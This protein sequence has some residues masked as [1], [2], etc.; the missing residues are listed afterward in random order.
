MVD[1]TESKTKPPPSFTSSGMVKRLAAVSLLFLL[2]A[3]IFEPIIPPPPKI[4]GTTNGPAVTSARTKLKDGRHVAY[5]EYGVPRDK[6]KNKIIFV[7]GFGCCRYD[8]LKVSQEVLEELSICLI[9]FDRPGYGESDPFPKKTVKSIATDIEELADNL[10]LGSK[11][12]VIGY[13]MGG[14]A[15]WSVLK[16]IPHRLAGAAILGPVINY[17]WSGFP[18]NVTN[19]AWNVQLLADKLA[20]SVAH[21]FP[22]LTHWWNTQKYF[23]SSS[24]ITKDARI[25]PPSDFPILAKWGAARASY[26]GQIRQ[27]GD[28]ESLF[29]DMIVGFSNWDF[30][31]LDLKNPFPNNEGSVHLWHGEKD[32]MVPVLVSRYIAQQLP[33][34]TYHELPSA[35]HMFPLDENIANTIVKSLIRED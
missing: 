6:A 35:G 28:H 31:P 32:W 4:C 10:Q 22:W 12:Y 3:L 34:I 23:P 30:S 11:F 18:K 8:V 15:M 29:R 14:E 25:F 24:V 16:Y 17:W 1:S 5:V 21:H 13:S 20:V 9:G 19:E 26:A 7:H 27:Q 33:W 2:A